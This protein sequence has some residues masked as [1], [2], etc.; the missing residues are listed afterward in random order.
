MSLCQPLGISSA[1]TLTSRMSSL[2]ALKTLSIPQAM[3]Y[4]SKQKCTLV[5]T[6]SLGASSLRCGLSLSDVFPSDSS[7]QDVPNEYEIKWLTRPLAFFTAFGSNRVKF[8]NHSE[9]HIDLPNPR[10]LAIH[11]ALAKVLHM[12]GAGECVDLVMD[13]F[14]PGS[15]SVLS[16]RFGGADLDIR[17]SVL[18]LFGE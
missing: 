3:E 7:P 11:A 2:K 9:D 17:L 8:E 10:L 6:T 12:S 5:L 15:S 14:N 13:K 16:G 1:T 4:S 18:S